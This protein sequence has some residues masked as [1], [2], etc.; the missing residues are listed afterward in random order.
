[1]KRTAANMQS[2]VIADVHL[3]E[4][5]KGGRAGPTPPRIFACIM[6]LDAQNFDVRLRLENYPLFPGQSVTL[7]IDFLDWER[8]EPYCKIG[9]DFRLRELRVIGEGVIRSVRER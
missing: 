2:D 3:Y 8:A 9:S 7:P 5:E 6:V 1:M 4:T